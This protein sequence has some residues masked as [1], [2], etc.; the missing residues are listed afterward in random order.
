MGV[1]TYTPFMTTLPCHSPTV[2]GIAHECASFVVDTSNIV[3]VSAFVDWMSACPRPQ[4]IRVY[5]P[6]VSRGASLQR[7]QRSLLSMGCTVTCRSTF[8]VPL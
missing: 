8:S 2:S 6:P 3:D 4:G 5:M 1:R 7:L